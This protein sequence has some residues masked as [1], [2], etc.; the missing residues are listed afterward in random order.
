VTADNVRMLRHPSS[1]LK[2]IPPIRSPAP[3][4]ASYGVEILGPPGTPPD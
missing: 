2:S 4:A 1:A 3:V